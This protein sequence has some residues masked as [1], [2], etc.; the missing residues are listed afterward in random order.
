MAVT[1]QIVRLPQ[2][3]IEA[4]RTNEKELDRLI[5]FELVFPDDT[6]DLDWAPMAIQ[7]ALLLA[8]DSM[9]AETVR[10]ACGGDEIVNPE[11][12]DGP[13][14]Y[15]VYSP[16]TFLTAPRVLELAARLRAIERNEIL[17]VL[18]ASREEAGRLVGLDGI[19]VHPK[20]YLGQHLAALTRFYADAA[21]RGLAVAMWDD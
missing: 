6:L 13:R 4:C 2:A 11:L 7:R 21:A 17:S 20:E 9:A 19:L 5:S 3:S 8:G 10:I 12:P 16:I 14:R 18:P 15:H 1:Q